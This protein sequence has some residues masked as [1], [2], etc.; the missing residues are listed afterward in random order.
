MLGAG[1]SYAVYA[2][3]A[4]HAIDRGLDAA[5]AMAGVFVLA[6]AL[7][8]P[9]LAVEP[10]GWL[11]TVR[12]AVMALHLGLFTIGLAYSLYGWGLHHLG[13]PVVVRTLAEPVAAATFGVALLGERIGPAGWLGATLVVAGLVLAGRS[14]T[15]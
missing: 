4:K 7:M 1:L 6:A 12:G 2:H 11:W 10:L 8:A 9:L 15:T 13:V 3:A 5:G 14:A